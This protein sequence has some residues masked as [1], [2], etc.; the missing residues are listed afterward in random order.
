M[1]R[2]LL[3]VIPVAALLLPAFA[4]AGTGE[5]DAT[6]VGV[7]SHVALLIG[8]VLCFSFAMKIYLLLKGGEMAVGWQMVTASFLLFT[9]SELLN[10]SASLEIVGLQTNAIRVLQVLALFLIL[11]G[12]VRIKKSLT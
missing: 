7:A 1:N 11:F 6:T 3:Y 9:V 2:F 12:V 5:A 4:L 10:I 8:G